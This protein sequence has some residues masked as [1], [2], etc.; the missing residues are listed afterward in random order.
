[1]RALR[2]GISLSTDFIVGFPSETEAD[3]EQTLALIDEARF[4]SAFSFHYSPRP[5]TPAANLRDGVPQEE[6]DRRLAL[7]Q[8]RIRAIDDEFKRSLVGTTQ[9]IL[10]ERAATKGHGQMTGRTSSNRSVNF[11]GPMSMIGQFVDVEITQA[12]TNSLRGRL[13]CT[14]VAA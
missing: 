4:D 7:L 11:D 1:M 10:V 9:R 2:P 8:A 12:M 3:F 5:G 14:A 6:K 13:A